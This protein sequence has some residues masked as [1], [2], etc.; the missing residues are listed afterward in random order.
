MVREAVKEDLYSLLKLYLFL[1]GENIPKMDAH[2]EDTWNQIIEDRNH[3]LIVKE[4]DG[5]IVDTI[6]RLKASTG[7]TQP[8]S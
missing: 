1:H 3:H 2:L 5:Q 4:I 8:M 7:I 6:R